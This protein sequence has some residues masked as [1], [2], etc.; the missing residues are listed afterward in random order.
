MLVNRLIFLNDQYVNFKESK[1]T[2]QFQPKLPKKPSSKVEVDK[3][4]TKKEEWS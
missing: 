4:H 2:I 3:V 1:K